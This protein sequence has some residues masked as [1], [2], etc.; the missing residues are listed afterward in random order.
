MKYRPFS[1][2]NY[3]TIRQLKWFGDTAISDMDVVGRVLPFKSNNY[4]V[5]ELIDCGNYENDPKYII[6]FPRYG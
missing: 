2:K 5:D 4:V 1:L 3:H 6:K